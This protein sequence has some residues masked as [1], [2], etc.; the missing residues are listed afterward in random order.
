MEVADDTLAY[1]IEKDE[2]GRLR[3]ECDDLFNRLRKKD[4]SLEMSA[5]IGKKLLE[6]NQELQKK[7]NNVCKEMNTI[8]EKLEQENY[9]L[10]QRL[11]ET[12][13]NSRINQ[14][15]ENENQ[16]LREV[17][18]AARASAETNQRENR[19][20]IQ[21]LMDQIEK[22]Q[23]Q[24][25]K[26][27]LLEAQGRDRIKKLETELN[28]ARGE[29]M[30][31]ANN[32]EYDEEIQ[33][34]RENMT[35]LQMELDDIKCERDTCNNKY[36]RANLECQT[37]EEHLVTRA[38]RISELEELYGNSYQSL[39][40]AKATIS[41]LQD[42]IAGLNTTMASGGRKNGTDLY[43]EVDEQ[44]IQLRKETQTLR[45]TINQMQ[46][47]IEMAEHQKTQ[48]RNQVS[49]LMH[50][51][52][53]PADAA[54]RQKLEQALSQT[55]SENMQLGA[56]ILSLERRMEQC[57]MLMQ[58]HHHTDTDFGEKHV[59]VEYLES[60]L[61]HRNTEIGRLKGELRTQIL[62]KMNESEKLRKAERMVHEVDTKNQSLMMKNMEIKM[63]I[64]DLELKISNQIPEIRSFEPIEREDSSESIS[65]LN[66]DNESGVGSNGPS[67]I[68]DDEYVETSRIGLVDIQQQQ[69]GQIQNKVTEISIDADNVNECPTQ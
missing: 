59:Y 60:E 40:D 22:L 61:Q 4:E 3:M 17:L 69:D 55:R 53:N 12:G 66:D 32:K 35:K 48:L 38:N 27:D 30:K 43:S 1:A 21:Q 14:E 49:M 33:E 16:N 26:N 54:E 44:R 28:Q 18:D 39:R 34:L 47:D 46:R 42:E 41:N 25:T 10:K 6:S 68:N 67:P 36:A 11:S 58:E 52:G 24:I 63:K 19:T 37:L 51:R 29:A 50:T 45:R 20:Q 8:S 23:T 64:E 62:Q 65:Q 13:K 5:R 31:M 15:L 7:Y 57:H 2:L 9:D 56:K